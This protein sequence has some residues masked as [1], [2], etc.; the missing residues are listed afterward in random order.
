MVTYRCSSEPDPKRRKEPREE[1][2]VYM[3]G[4][5]SFHAYK[6]SHDGKHNVVFRADGFDLVKNGRSIRYAYGFQYNSE[7]GF[8]WHPNNDRICYF[9]SNE[10]EGD[11][12][13]VVVVLEL[14][15]CTPDQDGQKPPH[16]TFYVPPPGHVPFGLEWSPKGDALYILEKL[17]EDGV[18]YSRLIRVTLAGKITQI[19]RINGLIDFFMPPVSRY[20][21]GEGSSTARYYIVFGHPTGLYLTDPTGRVPTQHVS[22]VPAVGLHN[23]EWHPR[24][25]QVLLFFQRGTVGP[26]G[27][28]FRGVYLVHLDRQGREEKLGKMLEPLYDDTDVHTLWYSPSG[29]YAT[30]ATPDA[31]YI[32][33]PGDPAEKTV[34]IV[35][36]HDELELEIKGVTWHRNE[37]KIAFTAGNHLFVHELGQES[38]RPTRLATFGRD[39]THFTAEPIWLGDEVYLTVFQDLTRREKT[40]KNTPMFE[41]PEDALKKRRSRSGR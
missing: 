38:A 27:K 34:E 16:K 24:K 29:T 35:A 23:I 39:T 8:Y 32:R 22:N 17:R 21:N 4:N 12:G 28:R 10:Q 2:S 37:R 18:M 7:R 3:A 26:D 5:W 1:S 15:R 33:K 31:I 40:R 20:E 36:T 19:A 14:A 30:W 25:N 9:G 13:R 11:G 6:R 41:N